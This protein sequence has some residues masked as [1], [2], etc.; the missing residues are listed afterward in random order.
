MTSTDPLA[1]EW[2]RTI[3]FDAIAATDIDA[4]TDD[5]VQ[6]IA[7]SFPDAHFEHRMNE[8]G[9][10]VRRVVV[11][12]EWEINPSPIVLAQA[13]S[14]E[15]FRFG[16]KVW[17]A[18]VAR[19]GDPDRRSDGQLIEFG[20]GAWHPV[21]EPPKNTQKPC[22]TCSGAGCAECEP[23]APDGKPWLNPLNENET[24]SYYDRMA[25][26]P[27]STGR[28]TDPA[29]SSARIPNHSHLTQAGQQA[30]L[31]EVIEALRADSDCPEPVHGKCT[32][33]V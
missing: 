8:H 31:A 27:L 7:T 15:G 24:E 11:E 29:C 3:L 20:E 33:E 28:C 21:D 9:A 6:A 12:G 25:N 16:R 13:E 4:S 18:R 26:P 2:F 1:Y 22:N 30:A 17:P 14:A 32:H 19:D 23:L 10:R 5:H